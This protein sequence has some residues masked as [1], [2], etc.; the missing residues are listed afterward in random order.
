MTALRAEVDSA[1]QEGVEMMTLQAPDSIEVVDEHCV[2]LITQP[3]RI[4]AV[5]RG[6][7]APVTAD[8]PQVRIPADIILIAVGQAIESAPFGRGWYA[9]RPNVFRGR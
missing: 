5:K 7:P 6:R 4:G 9:G 8:K 3:Q 1:M 2:A